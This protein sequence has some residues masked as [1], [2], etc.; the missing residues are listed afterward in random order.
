MRCKPYFLSL[1]IENKIDW[2]I[3]SKMLKI[4]AVM[5]PSTTN[6]SMK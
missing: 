1:K 4:S 6:P 5:K 2:E 3:E